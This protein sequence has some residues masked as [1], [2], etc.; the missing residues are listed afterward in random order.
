MITETI[1]DNKWKP[2]MQEYHAHF[3]CFSGAAGDMLL[4]ACLD[5]SDDTALLLQHVKFC[6]RKGLPEIADEFDISVSKVQRGKMASIAALHLEVE[7]KYN[8]TPVPVPLTSNTSQKHYKLPLSSHDHVH[9]HEHSHTHSHAHTR[10]HDHVNDQTLV[11]NTNH[12]DS[13][14]HDHGDA[15]GHDHEHSASDGNG[16]G[17]GDGTNH[18]HSHGHG[19]HSSLGPLRNLPQIRAM[20]LASSPEFIDPWVRDMAISAFTELARAEAETHGAD[21]DTVHFHEVGA[22]DSIVDSVGT[23]IALHALGVKSV[24]CSRLPIGEGTCWGMHGL[25]PV[26]APATLRLLKGM[27]TTPGPP[28]ITGE[29]VTPTGAALLRVLVQKGAPQN[30][31]GRPPCFTIRAIGHG[32]GTRDFEKHPNIVRLLLGDSMITMSNQNQSFTG[33]ADESRS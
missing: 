16:N 31:P 17:N 24:S 9:D 20:L 13:H 11:D 10:R 14:D 33:G 27:P 28:G 2:R 21:L 30:I 18:A 12:T 29:L 3:D 19:L 1:T 26:P 5:A 23:L 4:A 32:A 6:L 7:S 22:I 25:M 15:H 8:H